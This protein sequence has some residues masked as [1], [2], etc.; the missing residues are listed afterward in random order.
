M[1]TSRFENKVIF[2]TGGTSG[3]GLA[4]AIQ[5]ALEGAGTIIVSGRRKSTKV[6]PTKWHK[7]P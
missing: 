4:T 3:I 5:F 1:N 2:I 6:L 7:N